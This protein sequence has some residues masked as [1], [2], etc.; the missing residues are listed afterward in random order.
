MLKLNERFVVDAA[1]DPVEV[2]LSIAEYRALLNR[3]RELDA[4]APPL[5][6]LEQWSAEF[7]QALAK[8]GYTTREQ[9][10]ELTREVKREQLQAR[11]AR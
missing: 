6:P 9:I 10:L 11:L 1:G 3:L 4:T 2:I 7:H 8:A 5:P